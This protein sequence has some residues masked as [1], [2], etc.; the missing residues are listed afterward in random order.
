MIKIF[1]FFTI[2]CVTTWREN[3]SRRTRITEKNQFFL[4]NIDVVIYNIITLRL[5]I[6]ISINGINGNLFVYDYHLYVFRAIL[7]RTYIG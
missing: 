4:L 1:F 6:S 3:T 7:L 2:R 5:Y